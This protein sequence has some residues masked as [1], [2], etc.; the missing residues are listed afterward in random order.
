MD[1]SP[2]YSIDSLPQVYTNMNVDTSQE[3][4]SISDTDTASISDTAKPNPSIS[5]TDTASISNTA[6]KE[7]STNIPI[8]RERPTD[9]NDN[10]FLKQIKKDVAPPLTIMS[11]AINCFQASTIPPSTWNTKNKYK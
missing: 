3:N 4:P 10:V 5:N 8:K 11:F 2:D 9:D 1:T 6:K 7:D